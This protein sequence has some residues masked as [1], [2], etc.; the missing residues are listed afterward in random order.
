M[1]KSQSN[2]IAISGSYPNIYII[3]VCCMYAFLECLR[4][5][6][7]ISILIKVSTQELWTFQQ[8]HLR[9]DIPVGILFNIAY[10]PLHS[11]PDLFGLCRCYFIH[12]KVFCFY[13]HSNIFRIFSFQSFQ[14][15]QHFSP[16][17]SKYR[18]GIL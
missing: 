15:K 2:M 5:I 8:A 4:L 3:Y 7:E 14:R 16:G 11:Q 17:K 13:N 6:T 18:Y 9:F 12:M 10:N 1:A